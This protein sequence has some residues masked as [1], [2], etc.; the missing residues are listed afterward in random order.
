M[1]QQVGRTGPGAGPGG[2]HGDHGWDDDPA[3]S[4]RRRRTA[5]VAVAAAAAFVVAGAGTAWGLSAS[6]ALAS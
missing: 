2:W 5:A 3:R 6:G 4:Q 1:E